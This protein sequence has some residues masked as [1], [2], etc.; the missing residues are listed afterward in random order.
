MQQEELRH[1]HL[2]NFVRRIQELTQGFGDPL[3]VIGDQGCGRMGREQVSHK[4]SLS[5]LKGFSTF[6]SFEAAT[7]FVL[8]MLLM[9]V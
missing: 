8:L 9:L 6:E 3:V 2:W 4:V 7:C 1:H 5:T